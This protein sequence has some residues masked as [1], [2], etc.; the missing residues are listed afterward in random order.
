MRAANVLFSDR[1]EGQRGRN[2]QVPGRGTLCPWS[3]LLDRIGG[4]GRKGL[5]RACGCV[6][7]RHFCCLVTEADGHPDPTLTSCWPERGLSLSTC[8]LKATSRQS[9]GTLGCEHRGGS[10]NTTPPVFAA[11]SKF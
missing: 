7:I 3:R 10:S 5:K 1:F 2:V 8:V 9:P 4:F 11:L 6:T